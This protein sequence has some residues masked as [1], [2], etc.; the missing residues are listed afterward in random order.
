MASTSPG[1][2]ETPPNR[3][4]VRSG[5]HPE[6]GPDREHDDLCPGPGVLDPGRLR[7]GLVNDSPVTGY[8]V[9]VAPIGVQE[10]VFAGWLLIKGFSPTAR[11]EPAIR[12]YPATTTTT[13]GVLDP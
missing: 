6:A 7:R 10:L 2:C 9:L 8:V 12:R 1:C 11:S 3:C 5:R 13:S 4:A